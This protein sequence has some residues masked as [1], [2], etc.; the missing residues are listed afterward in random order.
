MMR[1]FPQLHPVAVSDT[2]STEGIPIVSAAWSS[3]AGRWVMIL[4][5]VGGR[6]GAAGTTQACAAPAGMP[7]AEAWPRFWGAVGAEERVAPALLAAG[8]PRWRPGDVPGH[9]LETTLRLLATGV[10]VVEAPA[11]PAETIPLYAVLARV[12][13]E[14]TAQGLFWSTFHVASEVNNDERVLTGRWPEVLREAWPT[15][16]RRLTVGERYLTEAK[17]GATTY[18]ESATIGWLVAEAAHGRFPLT[19]S[20]ATTVELA[21]ADASQLRPLTRKDAEIFARD[22]AT[23][24]QLN[25]L[26]D[27]PLLVRE[28]AQASPG[29]AALLLPKTTSRDPLHG[30][31]ALGLLLE[32][33]EPLMGELRTEAISGDGPLTQ[34][35]KPHL[36][37]GENQRLAY[38]ALAPY[39]RDESTLLKARAWLQGLGLTAQDTP[40]LFVFDPR[41]VAALAQE[42]PARAATLIT[43]Q[44]DPPRR[45]GSVLALLPPDQATTMSLLAIVTAGSSHP[46]DIERA[47]AGVRPTFDQALRMTNNLN[48]ALDKASND[49]IHR[50]LVTLGFANWLHGRGVPLD[51]DLAVAL[52]GLGTGLGPEEFHYLKPSARADPKPRGATEPVRPANTTTTWRADTARRPVR[53]KG[54]AGK[55][56]DAP[57]RPQPRKELRTPVKEASSRSRTW[58]VV[59]GIV[60]AAAIIVGLFAYFMLLLAQ[61]YLG[62]GA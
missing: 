44:P 31:L 13:P 41:E 24:P 4:R 16:V 56:R 46:N 6:F 37:A 7:L 20:V 23:A 15:D 61:Q 30:M 43:E 35:V 50:D 45:L 60:L 5:G 51:R 47:L 52:L 28:F 19:N 57:A 40:E 58:L 53:Q 2:R 32:R 48:D 29:L 1:R 9:E 11:T 42:S 3:Q 17:L 38:A 36:A 8:E 33:A 39:L 27:N 26:A 49:A 18:E 12:L 21:L 55:T 14:G 62:G 10:A 54:K 25:R 22:G 34:S 59:L